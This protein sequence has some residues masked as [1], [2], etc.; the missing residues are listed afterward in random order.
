[1]K[2]NVNK[3]LGQCVRGENS[4]RWGGLAACFSGQVVQMCSAADCRRRRAQIK[5]KNKGG[6]VEKRKKKEKR[7]ITFNG[8]KKYDERRS[9]QGE[10]ELRV[11]GRGG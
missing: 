5:N 11:W 7:K 6:T 8:R 4:G 1:M 10:E 2:T 9:V 3:A